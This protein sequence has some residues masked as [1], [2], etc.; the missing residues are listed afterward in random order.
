MMKKILLTIS[1]LIV[2]ISVGAQDLLR[3][4]NGDEVKVKVLEITSENIKYKKFSNIE[5]PLYTIS[6]TELQEIIF[7]NGDKETF[8][9]RKVSSDGRKAVFIKLTEDSQ[10][11][12]EQEVWK[13]EIEKYSKLRLVENIEDADLIFKFRI[14]RAM[15]E[16]RV[17]VLVFNSGSD[18]YLWESKKYRGTANVYNRMGASL[19]GIRRCLKKGIIPE[20]EKGTF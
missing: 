19:H 10:V 9:K 1:F 2:I 7:E 12:P 6:K 5:G 20:I 14:R 18:K 4:T 13:E 17:S 11:E 15:G 8:N 3:K 16:A